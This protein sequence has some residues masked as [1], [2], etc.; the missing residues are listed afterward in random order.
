MRATSSNYDRSLSNICNSRLLHS[1]QSLSYDRCG[2]VYSV[3]VATRAARRTT[4]DYRVREP[5]TSMAGGAAPVPKISD[6]TSYM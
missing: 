1:R 6:P 5:R 4:A 2:G 3:G